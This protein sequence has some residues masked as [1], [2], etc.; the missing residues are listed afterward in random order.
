MACVLHDTDCCS[1][2]NVFSFD[3]H[4]VNILKQLLFAE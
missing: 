2:N 4:E 3:E 1:V